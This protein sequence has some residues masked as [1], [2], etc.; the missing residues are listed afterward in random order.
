MIERS[1][2][3]GETLSL[4]AFRVGRHLP[5]YISPAAPLCKT[6]QFYDQSSFPAMK[7]IKA[8]TARKCHR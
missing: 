4:F 6:V 5:P 8:G 2:T 3:L 7:Y 1:E